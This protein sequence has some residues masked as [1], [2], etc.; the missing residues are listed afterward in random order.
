MMTT[1][2]WVQQAYR[3]LV[4]YSCK[5]EKYFRMPYPK[6]GDE[7][8]CLRCWDANPHDHSAAWVHVY[9]YVPEYRWYCQT[10]KHARYNGS[11]G[12]AQ[13]GQE[14]LMHHTKFLDHI[15]YEYHGDKI[16]HIYDG[17]VK[18]IYEGA[19]PPF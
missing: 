13:M 15:I 16:L 4:R 3:V 10:C 18:E 1:K 7:L 6:I 8:T 5:H 19:E 14:A 9:D 17:E 12:F 2:G 11:N